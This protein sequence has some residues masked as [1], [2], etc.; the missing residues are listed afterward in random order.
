MKIYS[1]SF[2][3]FV[4]FIITAQ[5]KQPYQIY[6]AKGNK[7]TYKKMLKT[8]A[9]A[10]VVLFGEQHDNALI[11]WLELEFAKDMAAQKPVAFGA[12]MIEADN[13]QALT[14]YL[15]G[16]VDQKGLDTLARLWPNYK[17][18]YKPLVEF[19]KAKKYIFVATNV[20]R[21]YASLVYKN[22]FSALDTLPDAEKKFMAPLPVAYDAELP[23]YKA[24]LQMSGMHGGENLPKAQALKDATMGYFIS[25]YSKPGTTFIHYNGSYH[26]DYHEGINWYLKKY[27]NDVSIVTIATVS[28][29]EVDTLQDEY[30]NKADFIIVVDEDMTT[31]Y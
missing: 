28:Q 20:P 14:G 21:H 27:K 23:G 2:F 8:A 3:L 1:L 18:D 9:D 29:K 7:T 13:Q 15:L 6:N 25:K 4:N 24:M 31:T 12:E 17:T 30:L 26:S 10:D 16:Q 19:A 22:G 5:D 11:H